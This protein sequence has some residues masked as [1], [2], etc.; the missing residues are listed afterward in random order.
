MLRNSHQS[1]AGGARIAW[2]GAIAAL[3][4][5]PVEPAYGGPVWNMTLNAN[6]SGFG[7]GAFYN[8]AIGGGGYGA[9]DNCC[10]DGSWSAPG[11]AGWTE[12][13][14]SA[15]GLRKD[16]FQSFGVT[17]AGSLQRVLFP[18]NAGIVVGQVSVDDLK[19]SGNGEA[20]IYDTFTFNAAGATSATVTDIAVQFGFICCS[21]YLDTRASFHL[22]AGTIEYDNTTPTI[23]SGWV[24]SQIGANTFDGRLE[25]HGSSVTVPFSMALSEAG[26]G[27]LGASATLSLPPGVTYSAYSASGAP[28][29]L[30]PEP[31]AGTLLLLGGLGLIGMRRF[32][33]SRSA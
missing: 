22:G 7:T 30:T 26:G 24:S 5:I 29:T 28:A 15:D 27:V 9:F 3:L 21:G 6:N 10:F 20:A 33:R 8:S 1:G 19:G 25:F 11:V 32:T 31:A 23:D 2:L 18:Q 16:D 4:L 13:S 12:A 14:V 17:A